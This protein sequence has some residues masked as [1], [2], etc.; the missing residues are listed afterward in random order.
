VLFVLICQLNPRIGN[1]TH[2]VHDDLTIRVSLEC[3]WVLESFSESDM[4]VDLSVDGKD[5]TSIVVDKRLSTSVWK[6]AKAWHG[7][8]RL[9]GVIVTG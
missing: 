9:E 7:L 1:I 8:A 5:D 4:V 3:S 6:S 2:Q